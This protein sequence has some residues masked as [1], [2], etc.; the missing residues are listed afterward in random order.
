MTT[1]DHMGMPIVDRNTCSCGSGEAAWWENDARGI[2]LAKVCSKCIDE[3]LSGFRQ[4]VRSDPNYW[5][6]EPIEPGD[7]DMAGYRGDDS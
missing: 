5:A 2:P 7:S 1:L 3:K 6:D 4:D